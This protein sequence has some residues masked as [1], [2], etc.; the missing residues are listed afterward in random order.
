MKYAVTELKKLVPNASFLEQYED[1]FGDVGKYKL[2]H[3]KVMEFITYTY[4]PKSPLVKQFPNIKT[5]SHPGPL[6][7][8]DGSPTQED[9][10]LAASIA[11]RFSK[12]K[13]DEQVEMELLSWRQVSS[14]SGSGQ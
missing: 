13:P 1:I 5:L 9:L 3:D 11:A 7:L 8:V 2:L 14:P 12:A 6:V 4:H 10:T